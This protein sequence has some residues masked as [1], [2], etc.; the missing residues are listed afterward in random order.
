MYI[1]I[2]TI[3]SSQHAKR[4]RRIVPTPQQ[5]QVK[6]PI[7]IILIIIVKEIIPNSCA[8][9]PP[10][11]RRPIRQIPNHGPNPSFHNHNHHRMYDIQKSTYYMYLGGLVNT[12]VGGFPSIDHIDTPTAYNGTTAFF[13]FLS[14]FL[15]IQYCHGRWTYD[16][17]TIEY[18]QYQ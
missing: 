5:Q 13:T 15:Y 9:Y 18:V 7:I 16:V 4:K 12:V 2:L 1:Y 6:R 10:N 11:S 14:F 3:H 8:R 17:R